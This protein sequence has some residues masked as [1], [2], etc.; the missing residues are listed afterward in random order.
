MRNKYKR[1][2]KSFLWWFIISL[3]LICFIIFTETNVRP[4]MLEVAI[5]D[6]QA[7]N[8]K[9]INNA[10]Y[11]A[12]ISEKVDFSSLIK[13]NCNENNQ[14]KSVS[15]DSVYL[16]KLKLIILKNISSGFKNLDIDSIS[17]RLGS[18]IDN[19]FTYGRG[20]NIKF[21]YEMTN[22]VDCEYKSSFISKGLNQS[23]HNFAIVFTTEVEIITPLFSTSTS[24][25]SEILLNEMVIVGEVPNSYTDITIKK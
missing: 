19:E 1:N 7:I 13:I 20:P 8:E 18:F 6:A 2:F 22:T 4:V 24:F 16:S 11:E 21:N 14:I 3:I 9:I 12:L 15:V 5:N 10:V 17:I 25:N 23:K